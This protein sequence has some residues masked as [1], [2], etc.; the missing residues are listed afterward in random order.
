MSESQ[1]LEVIKNQAIKYTLGET[2]QPPK[3]IELLY[4][5]LEEEGYGS[6]WPLD[7]GINIQYVAEDFNDEM[8]SSEEDIE[9][10]KINNNDRV[11]FARRLINSAEILTVETMPLSSVEGNVVVGYISSEMGMHDLGM[12]CIGL[13]KTE[14]DFVSELEKSDWFVF[15][16]DLEIMSDDSILAL[17]QT[18]DN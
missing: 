18:T 3:D 16:G 6:S 1:E 8:L 7:N 11:N 4:K 10:L 17:W 12:T 2:D 14:N 9:L 15:L 5:W 13:Y